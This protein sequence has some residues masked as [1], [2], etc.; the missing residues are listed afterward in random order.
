MIKVGVS[1]LVFIWDED[2]E[3]CWVNSCFGGMIMI[4]FKLEKLKF[5]LR[6]V[7]WKFCWESILLW[8][9]LLRVLMVCFE[10]RVVKSVRVLVLG[11]KMLLLVVMVICVLLIILLF[12]FNS[13]INLIFCFVGFNLMIFVCV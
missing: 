5:K 4:Y 13:D 10:I 11:S 9:V 12:I 8:L 3:S 1:L 2:S 7:V 6:F